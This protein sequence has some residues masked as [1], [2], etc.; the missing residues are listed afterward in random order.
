[1]G[2]VRNMDSNS[3]WPAARVRHANGDVGTYEFFASAWVH[4]GQKEQMLKAQAMLSGLVGMIVNPGIRHA[5]CTISRGSDGA[6][7]D[8]GYGGCHYSS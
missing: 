1:M 2:R 7:A 8:G 4:V 5:S 3:H 6:S